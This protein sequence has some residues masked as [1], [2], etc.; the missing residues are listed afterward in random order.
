[1]QVAVREYNDNDQEAFIECIAQLQDH[2]GLLDPLQRARTGK[3]FNAEAYVRHCIEQHRKKKEMIY[4]AEESGVVLGCITGIIHT[5][6]DD[7][8]E[9]YPS[10]DGVIQEV[11][12]HPDYRKQGVGAMLI[13][14][15]EEYFWS[16]D[17]STV[18]LDC[19]AKNQKAHAFY[20]KLGYEDRRII[21][22][23]SRG[24]TC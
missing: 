19:F 1:M 8:L 10:K 9:R 20:K 14:K 23:K 2:D 6:S 4:I 24:N 7:H 3:D 15:M 11:F 17:C 21:M 18:K 5:I 12:I 22:L 16:Q 13:Q